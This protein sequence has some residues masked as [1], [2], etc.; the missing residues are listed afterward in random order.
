M[1]SL[2]HIA[3]LATHDFDFILFIEGSLVGLFFTSGAFA[4]TLAFETGPGGPI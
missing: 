1:C 3:Y 2:A 4:M